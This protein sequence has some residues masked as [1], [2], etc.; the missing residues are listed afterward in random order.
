MKKIFL[1]T[2]FF[3]LGC[4]VVW[5]APNFKGYQDFVNANKDKVKAMEKECHSAKD[6][7][8]RHKKCSELMQF[9]V[10]AECRYGISPDACKALD[11]IKKIEKKKK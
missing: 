3:V 8:E 6:A 7:K 5:S 1:G 4:G 9:K 10:E 11:E 2:L